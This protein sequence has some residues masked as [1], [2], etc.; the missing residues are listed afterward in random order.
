M[1]ALRVEIFDDDA[2]CADRI[3]LCDT[4]RNGQCAEEATDAVPQDL[5]DLNRERG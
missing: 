3:A 5:S 4:F 2:A 1:G